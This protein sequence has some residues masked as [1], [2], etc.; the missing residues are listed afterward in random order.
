M[1]YTCKYAQHP[2]D[3]EGNKLP[4]SKWKKGEDYGDFENVQLPGKMEVCP[5]CEG[6]GSHVNPAVD[7]NGLTREDF[8]EDPDFAEDYFG[9]V[10]DICC[11]ECKGMR[12]VCV[13]DIF[14]HE[15]RVLP[16]FKDIWEY[17]MR[18]E[19][20]EYNDRR[21]QWYEMGCPRDW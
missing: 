5:R 16:E 9:G 13:P 8:D 19:Q 18:C 14:D 17:E 1:M 21:T 2:H 10:F 6:K 12:V 3:E 11:E 20:E 4:L 7:G 15:D